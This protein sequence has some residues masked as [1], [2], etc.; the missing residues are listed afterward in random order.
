MSHTQSPDK[1]EK[2]VRAQAYLDKTYMK[3]LQT[4]NVVPYGILGVEGDIYPSEKFPEEISARSIPADEK[5]QF[6]HTVKLDEAEKKK[7]AEDDRYM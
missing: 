7:K 6:E 4:R 3:N 1:W 5:P 2:K